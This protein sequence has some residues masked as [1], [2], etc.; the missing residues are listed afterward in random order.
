MTTT[1][2]SCH[3]CR[4]PIPTGLAVLRSIMWERVAFCGHC[5]D[6]RCAGERVPA[7]RV[8]GSAS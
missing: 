7:Q 3:D 5:W 2:H 4:A 8:G 1:T 6:L